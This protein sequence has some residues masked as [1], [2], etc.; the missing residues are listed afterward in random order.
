MG[1]HKTAKTKRIEVRLELDVDDDARPSDV[2]EWLDVVL[3]LRGDTGQIQ[4]V[5]KIFYVIE[6]PLPATRR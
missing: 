1:N 3:P 4:G 6:H 5:H 2:A